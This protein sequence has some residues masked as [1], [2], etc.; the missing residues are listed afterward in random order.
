VKT[1]NVYALLS[2]VLLMSSV[3]VHAQEAAPPQFE[4]GFNYGLTRVNPG[5]TAA[6]FTQNGGSGY[7]EYNINKVLGLVADLG[8]YHNG[9]ING[10]KS[11]IRRSPTCSG[12]ASTGGCR[13]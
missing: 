12:L 10:P 9:E 13:N 1:I 11:T 6:D 7:V 8:A 5:G 3:V 4:V 2:G